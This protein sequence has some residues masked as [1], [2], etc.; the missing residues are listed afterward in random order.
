MTLRAQGLLTLIRSQTL[1][2]PARSR[3]IMVGSLVSDFGLDGRAL[4]LAERIEHLR[5]VVAFP[6]QDIQFLLARG[7]GRSEAKASVPA[8]KAAATAVDRCMKLRR[9][10][11]FSACVFLPGYG[12]AAGACVFSDFSTYR[13]LAIRLQSA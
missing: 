13:K 9:D 8:A 12:K 3:L 7:L 5:R 11:V 6:A 1:V 10:R 2:S 4:R